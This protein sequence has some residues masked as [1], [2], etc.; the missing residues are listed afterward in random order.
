M[1]SSALA[2][3]PA[4]LVAGIDWG[5]GDVIRRPMR[6]KCLGSNA[7]AVELDRSAGDDT[8]YSEL[9]GISGTIEPS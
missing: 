9:L 7:L 5:L 3:R 8:G 6:R 2:H 1:F 4:R